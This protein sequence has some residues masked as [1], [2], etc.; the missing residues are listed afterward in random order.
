MIIRAADKRPI[1]TAEGMLLS[2]LG[3]GQKLMMTE[4]SIAKGAVAALHAHP[5]EQVTYVVRGTVQFT[6]GDETIV[7]APGDSCFIAPDVTH[8]AEALSDCLLVDAFAPPRQDFL[9]L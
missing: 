4:V 3:H 5:H 1:A 8:G 9:D 7:L 6:L 2:V